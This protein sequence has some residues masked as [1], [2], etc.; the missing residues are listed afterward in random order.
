MKIAH[1]SAWE[2]Y[3]SVGGTEHF[4]LDISKGQMEFG[5]DV[6]IVCP[7]VLDE[8]EELVYDGVKHYLFSSPNPL[9]KKNIS[10][11]NLP[12]SK[13]HEWKNWLIL[14]EVEILHI[15]VFEPYVIWYLNV[16]ARLGIKIFLTPHI[17]LLTCST[18]ELIYNGKIC[19][20]SI[21]TLKCAIC[22]INKKKKSKENNNKLN[23]WP[24]QFLKAITHVRSK[25]NQVNKLSKIITKFIVLTN[26][27]KRILLENHIPIEKIEVLK[28]T[29]S[30][31][32]PS[33]S[34]DDSKFVISFIGRLT[35]EKGFFNLIE[36]LNHVSVTR[37]ILVKFYGVNSE[38][39]N[40][41]KL[42]SELI[43]KKIEI[44][45]M[46]LFDPK[47]LKQELIGTHFI[48][49]PSTVYEMSPLVIQEASCLGIPVIGSSIGGIKEYIINHKNGLL[50][51]NG[52]ISEL[53]KIIE[54]NN[55]N[56]NLLN[57]MKQNILQSE[58]VFGLSKK[59]LKVYAEK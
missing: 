48:C 49:I 20:G 19:D 40:L 44:K 56:P 24:L 7:N 2:N 11:G 59:V 17:A 58:G 31:L 4:I 43:K 14:A 3:K 26:D 42:E 27:Y 37:P 21:N 52:N 54:E 46:G 13:L 47:S 18:G 22:V 45:L 57:S 30:A 9:R 32:A 55:A 10:N 16:A 12:S 5:H 29:Y 36:A 15:H 53:S 6:T 38:N 33:I 34:I 51:Q 23:L 39:I 8:E 25:Q 50:F 1:F 41:E 35:K 28:Y